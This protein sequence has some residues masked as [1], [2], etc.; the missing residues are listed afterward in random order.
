MGT[1]PE[2]KSRVFEEGGAASGDCWSIADAR[3]LPMATQHYPRDGPITIGSE[4]RNGNAA[5]D[6]ILGLRYLLDSRVRRM[7][8]GKG[9]IR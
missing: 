7:G 2:T 1:L 9:K 6:Q 3:I 8:V 4:S 5:R